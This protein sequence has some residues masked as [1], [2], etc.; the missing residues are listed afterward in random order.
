MT[1]CK[2]CKNPIIRA[3]VDRMIFDGV[4][5]ER[6][7]ESLKSVGVK[8]AKTSVLRHRHNHPPT[9]NP[10]DTVLPEGMAPENDT[11][12]IRPEDIKVE[13]DTPEIRPLG[14]DAVGL[15]DEIKSMVRS[16]RINLTEDRLVR[17]LLLDKIVENHLAVTASALN[18]YLTGDGRYPLDMIKGLSLVMQLHEKTVSSATSVRGTKH[19]IIEREVSRLTNLVRDDARNRVY[20]GERVS[21]NIP[22][23]YLQPKSD[24]GDEVIDFVFGDTRYNGES[25]NTRMKNAWIEG[26]ETG[27]QP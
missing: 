9:S 5:D 21:K 20:K 27:V 11:L 19:A 23:E 25:F 24:F 2:V 18:Q 16:D 4:S 22:V 8:V 7:A 14:N 1:A 15:L 10:A 12:D 6:I 17:E 13:S 3:Q 26:I